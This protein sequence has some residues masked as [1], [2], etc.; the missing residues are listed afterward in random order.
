[1]VSIYDSKWKH[2]VATLKGHSV[3]KI[4]SRWSSGIESREFV[5][6]EVVDWQLLCEKNC[7]IFSP[8]YDKGLYNP[9]AQRSSNCIRKQVRDN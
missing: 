8:A 5:V 9:L 1:M 6:C 3:I 4:M 2:G 7:F